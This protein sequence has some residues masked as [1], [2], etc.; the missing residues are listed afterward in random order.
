MLK[1]CAKSFGT[2]LVF[3]LRISAR[4]FGMKFHAKSFGKFFL[5]KILSQ[6]FGTVPKLSA[7]NDISAL[8]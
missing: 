6:S 5:A 2:V 4:N 8:R 1:F 3:W 7:R